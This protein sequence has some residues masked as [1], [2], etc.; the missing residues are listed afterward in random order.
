[1]QLVQK[2][3]EILQ[4]DSEAKAE[5][6][7]LFLSFEGNDVSN[8]FFR[9]LCLVGSWISK[10]LYIVDSNFVILVTPVLTIDSEF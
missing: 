9:H 10:H 5:K 1:M 7:C 4:K 6:V 3:F 2:K 8:F